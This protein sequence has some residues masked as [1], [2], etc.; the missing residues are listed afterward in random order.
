MSDG[1]V[2]AAIARLTAVALAAEMLLDAGPVGGDESRRAWAE[3]AAAVADWR[4]VR[5]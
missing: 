4:K 1:H 2:G 5:R 3:L